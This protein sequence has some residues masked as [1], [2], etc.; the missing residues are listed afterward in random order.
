MTLVGD[1]MGSGGAGFQAVVFAYATSRAC[2]ELDGPTQGALVGQ[3]VKAMLEGLGW[4]AVETVPYTHQRY[5]GRFHKVGMCQVAVGATPEV[6]A[7]L[8]QV[9]GIVGGAVDHPILAAAVTDVVAPGCLLTVQAFRGMAEQ[10]SD[11]VYVR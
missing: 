11:G 5:P 9:L 3:A 7:H 2:E 4:Q 6:T 10:R 1:A 8:K